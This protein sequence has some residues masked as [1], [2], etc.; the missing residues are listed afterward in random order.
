MPPWLE[1]AAAPPF[2][3]KSARAIWLQIHDRLHAALSSGALPPGEK[4]PSETA[5]AK[6]FGVTRVTLRRALR[7]LQTAGLLQARKGVGVF[8]RRPGMVYRVGTGRRFAESFDEVEGRMSTRTLALGH[9]LPSVEGAAGLGLDESADVIHLTRL[10]LQEGHPVYL[11]KKEFPAELFPNFA[12]VYAL[13]N[14]VTA[15][16]KAHG[17]P[18]YYWSETRVAGGFAENDEAT[19][20]NLSPRTPVL[21]TF[22]FNHDPNGQRIEHTKGCWPLDQVQLR[23]WAR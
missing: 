9:G 11:A 14:S 5:L 18:K 10:H 22:S 6:R 8:A 20:L 12:E 16:F 15:V 19:A 7:Q 13:D 1:D 23:F 4:L 17:I 21:R 2:E 3:A